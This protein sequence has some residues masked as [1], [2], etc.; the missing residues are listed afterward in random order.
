[1]KKIKRFNE[2]ITT[3]KEWYRDVTNYVVSYTRDTDKT[4]IDL[5]IGSSDLEDLC[6]RLR[7]HLS[8][9]EFNSI[10]KIEIDQ[11]RI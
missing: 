1:M 8:D 4:D 9:R 6:K 7:N 11:F 5:S 10:F 2:D 3:K